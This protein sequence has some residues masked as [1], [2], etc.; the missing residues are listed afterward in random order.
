MVV[1]PVNAVEHGHV[2]LVNFVFTAGDQTNKI[3]AVFV[4]Q[5]FSCFITDFTLE[6]LYAVVT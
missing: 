3:L 4:M 2:M 6:Q 5:G 1:L